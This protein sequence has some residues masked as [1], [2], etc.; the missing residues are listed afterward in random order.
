MS[1][2]RA[3]IALGLLL[4]AASGIALLRGAFGPALWLAGNG[5][6][7]S[8]GIAWERWRYRAPDT[9]APGPGWQRTDERIVDADSGRV[10]EV[11]YQPA[12]GERR[13]IEPR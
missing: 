6:V 5:L 8:A 9:Q 10:T 1:L 12:T 3:L 11:W 4:L 2:R 13:Y 7:L